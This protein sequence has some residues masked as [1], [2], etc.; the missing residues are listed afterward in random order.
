MRRILAW[1]DERTA[2][3]IAAAILASAAP[4]EKHCTDAACPGRQQYVLAEAHAAIARMCGSGT[5]GVETGT[6]CSASELAAVTRM[7]GPA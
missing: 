7:D 5:A 4:A 2:G 1:Q 6:A 3:R